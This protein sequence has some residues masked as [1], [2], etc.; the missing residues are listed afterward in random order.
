MTIVQIIC[1]VSVLLEAAIAD[2]ELSVLQVSH[3]ALVSR[4]YSKRVSHQKMSTRSQLPGSNKTSRKPVVWIHIRKS[5]GTSMCEQARKNGERVIEPSNYNCNMAPEDM[6][7]VTWGKSRPR[8]SC[9]ERVARYRGFTYGQIERPIF[10]SDLCTNDFVY[11]IAVRDPIA[12]LES[13]INFDWIDSWRQ[14]IDCI[15]EAN[16]KS[17]PACTDNLKAKKDATC[18]TPWYFDNFIVRTLAGY[19]TLILPPGAINS[20]HVELA[21]RTL[22]NISI[23]VPVEHL[24]DK[25]A[26]KDLKNILGWHLPRREHANTK[27]HWMRFAPKDVE[28]LRQINRFDIEIY[29]DIVKRYS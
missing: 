29:N 19:D 7:S 16:M 15:S 3:Q 27:E 18:V 10:S 25:L 26:K 22:A 23:Q 4:V 9:S 11:G 8:I 14:W 12:R 5:A 13:Q 28:R 21:R 6:G 20:S 24:N 1:V 2:D 17:C